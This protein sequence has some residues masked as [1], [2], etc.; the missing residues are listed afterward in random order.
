MGRLAV[1]NQGNDLIGANSLTRMGRLARWRERRDARSSELF[2]PHGATRPSQDK[3]QLSRKISLQP[4]WG[5]SPKDEEFR[6]S[7]L[8]SSLTRMGRLATADA[9]LGR[10]RQVLFNPHGATRPASTLSQ[11]SLLWTL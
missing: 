11:T 10:W 8:R 1:V 2:N 9:L 3:R 5:D 4:A 7:V 6:Q